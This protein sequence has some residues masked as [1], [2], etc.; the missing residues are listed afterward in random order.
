MA[1]RIIKQLID[2]LDQTEIADGK[3]G[4]VEFALRGTTYRID[5]SDAN[6]AKLEKAFAPFI[7][8]AARTSGPRTGTPRSSAT[9]RKKTGASRKSKRVKSGS[10]AG[11]RTW[12]AENGHEISARGRI[13]AAVVSAYDSAHKRSR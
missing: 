6:I 3:G 10:S 13:P 5:L 11:I 4:S 9:P 7:D 1:E 12:A 8:A 2:D